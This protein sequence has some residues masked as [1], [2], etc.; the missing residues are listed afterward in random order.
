ME[1]EFAPVVT[2]REILYHLPELISGREPVLA[3]PVARRL[4]L[5]N[6]ECREALLAVAHVG[7]A[8][9]GAGI[10]HGG[11]APNGGPRFQRVRRQA[12]TTFRTETANLLFEAAVKEIEL[13][14][15]QLGSVFDNPGST[16][17]TRST[18]RND[19]EA[20]LRSILKKHGPIGTLSEQDH[21]SRAAMTLSAALSH[22]PG[23]GSI[24]LL[25]AVFDQIRGAEVTEDRV[26]K[27]ASRSTRSGDRACALG[28]AA[29]IRLEAG[30]AKSA[31]QH[32]SSAVAISDCYPTNVYGAALSA[33]LLGE[34]RSSATYLD[35]LGD[36][37]L[38]SAQLS[39]IRNSLLIDS[40]RWREAGRLDRSIVTRLFDTL[41][42]DIEHG[43]S[44]K[45]FD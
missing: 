6:P 7:F 26:I 33:A 30:D 27:I 25:S 18:S 44:T 42:S 11:H 10:R 19:R 35:H 4:M 31:H 29:R 17:G 39:D 45:G 20:R 38:D 12:S 40:S 43:F 36:L 13:L 1:P 37:S 23:N 5:A 28:L 8:Y 24:L 41:Q 9:A 22:L 2:P 34:R 32:Y 15:R 16:I 21:A 14:S 3:N